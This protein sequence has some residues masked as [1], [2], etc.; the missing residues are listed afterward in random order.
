MGIANSAVTDWRLYD[1]VYT[2]RYMGLLSENLEGYEASSTLNKAERLESSLLLIHSALDDNVH[3]VN[4]M[5]L[6]TA[7]ASV[8]KDAEMRF[9]P[10]GAH[11][12]AFDGASYVLMT[13]VYT[14]ALCRWLKPD[15]VVGDPNR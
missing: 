6:L 9:Y 4:T 8:G 15:C 3:P 7:L 12:A 13:E 2:E 10:P 5:R 11:G 14:D 1:S